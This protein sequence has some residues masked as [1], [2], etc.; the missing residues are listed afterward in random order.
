MQI[1]LGLVCMADLIERKNKKQQKKQ[2][3]TKQIDT[4]LNMCEDENKRTIH[5]T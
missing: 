1:L 3:N 5:A 4:K 2:K